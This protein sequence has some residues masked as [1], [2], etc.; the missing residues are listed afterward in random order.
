MKKLLLVSL[1]LA[2]ASSACKDSGKT[3]AQEQAT[4]DSAASVAPAE[5]LPPSPPPP[6]APTTDSAAAA[7]DTA[8]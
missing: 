5:D 2:L 6:V 8:K 3:P 4:K 1:A 7:R